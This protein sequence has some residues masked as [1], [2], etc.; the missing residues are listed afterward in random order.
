[1]SIE[2]IQLRI[3]GIAYALSYDLDQHDIEM[4]NAELD[5]LLSLIVELAKVKYE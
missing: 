4:L 2:S 1:M 5:R 3:D